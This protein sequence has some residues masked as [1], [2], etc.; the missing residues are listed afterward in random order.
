MEGVPFPLCSLLLEQWFSNGDIVAP[1]FV[2]VWDILGYNWGWGVVTGIW[3]VEASNAAKP[4]AKQG[5][6]PPPKD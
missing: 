2:N 6:P 5:E 1:P 3:W 4:P